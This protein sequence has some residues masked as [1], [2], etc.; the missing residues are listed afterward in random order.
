MPRKKSGVRSHWA[1]SYIITPMVTP[2]PPINQKLLKALK[3]NTHPHIQLLAAKL[4]LADSFP[5]KVIPF[6]RLHCFQLLFGFCGK[7]TT[8][9]SPAKE[10]LSRGR[11]AIG[12]DT[13]VCATAHLSV[14]LRELGGGF[15]RFSCP[16]AVITGRHHNHLCVGLCLGTAWLQEY[17]S[18]SLC[19]L[20]T[21]H[22]S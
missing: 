19:L 15:C 3:I 8:L 2:P 13:D 10:E 17:V 6:V 1:F 9:L 4:V 18:L 21:M 16:A 7:I 5:C 12:W 11:P 22:T 14:T 20:L